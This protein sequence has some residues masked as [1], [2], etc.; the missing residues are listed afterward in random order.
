MERVNMDLKSGEVVVDRYNSHLHNSAARI[1]PDALARIDS[2]G[3]QFLAEEVDFDRLIG[4]TSCV[5]TGPRDI[6]VYAKRPKRFGHTR[7]VKNRMLEPATS[8][9]I[10]LKKAEDEDNL[11][12]LVTAFIGRLAEPE[13]WDTRAFSRTADSAEAERKSHEFWSTHALLWGT[14]E[15]IPG[16]ETATCPW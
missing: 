13:P 1:L 5:A 9:V 15:I 14:E 3:R 12:V 4:G 2:K 16:T 8:L 10:I 6:I 11:Y 7:F